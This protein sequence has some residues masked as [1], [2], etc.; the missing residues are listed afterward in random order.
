M[1]VRNGNVVEWKENMIRLENK[2]KKVVLLSRIELP[3]S[4]LPM[5][6]SVKYVHDL[7][8]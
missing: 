5:E 3:T 4:P 8:G 7:H 1:S 2:R 6:V